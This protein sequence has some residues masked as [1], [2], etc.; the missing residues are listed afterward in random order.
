MK[1]VRTGLLVVVAA[2]LTALAF[3]YFG[4]SYRIT[5]TEV[6]AGDPNEAAGTVAESPSFKTAS[7]QAN[8]Q[9]VA[10]AVPESMSPERAYADAESILRCAR[11]ADSDL[12]LPEDMTPD[13]KR[14]FQESRVRGLD[15]SALDSKVSAYDLAKFAAER[16]NLQAQ[17]NFPGIASSVFNEEKNALDPKLIAQYKSDSMRFL[18]MA[19]ATGS[20][21][22]YGRL[23]E[24][25]Q[26]GLF[27][28][29]D[30]VKGYAYAYAKSQLSPMTV[31]S[32]WT[33]LFSRGL[34]PSELLEAQQLGERLIR[35]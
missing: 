11:A 32:S 18:N 10:N 15:C 34:S 14:Q 8:D 3:L 35:K 6:T 20:P 4:T 24:N 30:K 7:A 25:Y 17:L 2:A 27:S 19:A 29:K 9:R 33:E 16:G 5:K 26:V 28:E 13:E 12:V 21:E 31:S 23:A 22:A 1:I